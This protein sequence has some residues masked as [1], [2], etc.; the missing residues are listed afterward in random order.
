VMSRPISQQHR[1]DRSLLL[2][3]PLGN[4]GVAT[5]VSGALTLKPGL[6]QHGTLLSGSHPPSSGL[7]RYGGRSKRHATEFDSGSSIKMPF[8]AVTSLLFPVGKTS[9]RSSIYLLSTFL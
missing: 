1:D 5:N 8:R 2:L 7:L 4:V 3:N 9:K 6:L